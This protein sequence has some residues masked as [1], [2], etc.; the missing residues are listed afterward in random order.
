MKKIALFVDVQNIYY[1]CRQAYGKQFNYRKLWQHLGYEGDIVQA[2]AYA[3]HRGDDGQLK[4]QDALKHIGFA[5]KL[6][7][8]IQRSDGSAKGDWDVGITID[9]M[10]AAGEVDTIIL[11]SGDGDFDLLMQKIQQKHGVETQVYGVPS[12]TAKSLIDSVNQFHEIDH[13][14][15]L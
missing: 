3:I 12:L 15:L 7:P 8:F 13:S 1:T 6:K 4:F 11:L 10:E 14:L 9:I 5:V 2:T